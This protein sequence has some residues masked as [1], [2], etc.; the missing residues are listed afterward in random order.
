MAVKEIRVVNVF[1]V[2]RSPDDTFVGGVH[3]GAS[4]T[5][6]IPS[7]VAIVNHCPVN[8]VSTR[9]MRVR[10]NKHLLLL[11]PHLG[12]PYVASRHPEKLI[13]RHVEAGQLGFVSREP[14]ACMQRHSRVPANVCTVGRFQAA[15][16]GYRLS[17]RYPPVDLMSLPEISIRKVC[18]IT[19]Q[20]KYTGKKR[21]KEACTL[22]KCPRVVTPHNAFWKDYWL[23]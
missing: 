4:S 15:V 14:V 13:R 1:E 22:S 23:S 2:S 19:E 21:R 20:V 12:A 17:L 6:P 9:R 8:S 10:Q 16:V 5:R 7:K 11:L 18:T 3:R